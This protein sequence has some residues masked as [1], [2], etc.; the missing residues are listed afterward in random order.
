[1]HGG[2]LLRNVT[3]AAFRPVWGSRAGF[4]GSPSVAKVVL[5][6]WVVTRP[7]SNTR[8][9]AMV[10]AALYFAGTAVSWL[11]VFLVLLALSCIS[12]ALYAYN[13]AADREQD[14][15]IVNKARYASAAEL[16]GPARIWRIVVSLL[17]LGG[18]VALLLGTPFFL[19]ATALA[20]VLFAYSSP[21]IR[22]K[23][24]PVLDVVF[25]GALTHPLRFAAAW[26]AFGIGPPPLLAMSG[27]LF[28]KA[29]GYLLYKAFDRDDLLR[30]GIQNSLTRLSLRQVVL[31]ALGCTL[32]AGVSG[33][34]MVANA[35]WQIPRLGIL[36]A[37]ALWLV[38]AVVPPLAVLCARALNVVH[39]RVH[40]LR[41]VG[42][43]YWLVWIAI[44]AGAVWGR[45]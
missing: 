21:A 38:V 31:L 14:R 3:E 44:V 19:L 10:L 25:G 11:R 15:K 7:L 24:R 41:R 43:V 1:M 42:Y 13:A 34:L 29:G 39:W 16:L 35:R 26:A 5:A 12:S 40:V 17:F 28:A 22:L 18:S 45:P 2:H 20:L 23:E 9:L 36:P 6:A 37:R 33:V 8:N 32:L 30:L 27:L 4:A